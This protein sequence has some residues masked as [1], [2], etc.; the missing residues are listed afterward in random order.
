M[1]FRLREKFTIKYF[2]GENILIYGIRLTLYMMC[3]LMKSSDIAFHWFSYNS[4]KVRELWWYGLPPGVR[5]EVWKR[6]I[7]NDLNISP[8][9]L[10]PILYSGV[11][12]IVR[13][14]GKLCVFTHNII[15]LH[16]HVLLFCYSFSFFSCFT[17]SLSQTCFWSTYG[18]AVRD[19]NPWTRGE[20]VVSQH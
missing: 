1:K 3:C 12:V 18:V 5:G 2:T 11:C 17:I 7:G 4:R 8:G 10:I 14:C 19:W 16:L 20:E 13:V 15:I 9:L 6:A